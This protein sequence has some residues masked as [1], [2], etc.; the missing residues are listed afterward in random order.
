MFF[1]LER[2]SLGASESRLAFLS[3][4][5]ATTNL[6]WSLWD[7]YL[8]VLGGKLRKREAEYHFGPSI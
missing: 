7:L 2:H 4:G 5:T 3:G 1:T 8:L 6:S